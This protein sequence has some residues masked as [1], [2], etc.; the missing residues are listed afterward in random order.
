M[1]LFHGIGK[2]PHISLIHIHIQISTY[3]PLFHCSGMVAS[4][5]LLFY[6]IV[7]SVAE[8]MAV[9]GR[10]NLYLSLNE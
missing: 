1:E 4:G 8:R 5:E 10:T 3:P 9:L 2:R 6:I 7:V